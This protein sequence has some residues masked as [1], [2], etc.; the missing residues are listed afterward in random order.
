MVAKKKVPRKK[1]IKKAK[2]KALIPEI[3][4]SDEMV[5][6]R[7]AVDGTS[8]EE[9]SIMQNVRYSQEIIQEARN[10]FSLDKLDEEKKK[11]E[12]E[13]LIEG[14]RQIV[15]LWHSVEAL[16][17]HTTLFVVLFLI[18]IG[19]ILNK[20]KSSLTTTD[21]VKW[22]NEIFY[23]K[24]PRY[25]QQAHQLAQ[26]GEFAKRYASMGKKRLLALDSLRKDKDIDSHENL[27]DEHPLSEEITDN[28]ITDEMMQNNPFPD[29]TEDM[30]GKLLKEHV[31]GMITY[32]RFKKAGIK[33]ISFDQAYL[34]AA[35]GKNA[36]GIKTVEKIQ[37]ELKK[38]KT[39]NA[40]KNRLNIII[41]DKM[42]FPGEQDSAPAPRESINQMLANFVSYCDNAD[43]EDRSWIANQKL[44]VEEDIFRNANLYI[45]KLGRKLGITLYLKK[46][47]KVP[48]KKKG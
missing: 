36:L 38:F 9:I 8:H 39:N 4:K 24:H 42:K 48:A 40:K 37:S 2:A 11:G 44:L 5:P 41:M 33:F 22:R 28:L 16:M 14:E 12:E 17:T 21:Y 7:L 27:F 31:D 3:V 45:K 23:N 34:M 15:K 46:S 18:Y 20:I 1:K 10:V 32:E 43:L 25:L 30:D 26:M 13:L 6:V 35:Y 47:T 19:E 29:S